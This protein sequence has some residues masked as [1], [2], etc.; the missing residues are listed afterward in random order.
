VVGI[1]MGGG[2]AGAQPCEPLVPGTLTGPTIEGWVPRYTLHYTPAQ[3]PEGCWHNGGGVQFLIP[4]T[5]PWWSSPEIWM[6]TGQP[7]NLCSVIELDTTSCAGSRT[8][9]VMSYAGN[10]SSCCWEIPTNQVTIAWPTR[11]PS[12]DM[13]TLDR[14]WV[15]SFAPINVVVRWQ[16]GAEHYGCVEWLNPQTNDWEQV[17]GDACASGSWVARDYATLPGRRYYRLWAPDGCGVARVVAFGSTLWL[18]EHC[19][20]D[21]DN[22]G[23]TGTDADIEAFFRCL[24]GACCENC[25]SQDFNGDGDFGTD[26]DIEAFFRVLAGGSCV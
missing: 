23:D 8:I 14:W 5:P 7:P 24:A 21:F 12:G 17:F 2:S 15:G 10:S 20:A 26:Q 18:A 19:A 11:I 4:D 9:R 3:L 6:C 22:D 25:G 13:T 1:L 16:G